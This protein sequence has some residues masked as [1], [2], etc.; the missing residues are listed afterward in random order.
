MKNYVFTVLLGR[1]GDDGY[2]AVC[3]AFPGCRARG[4][5]Q[6]ETIRKIQGLIDR[7][8]GTVI[9]S[10]KQVPKDGDAAFTS[11]GKTR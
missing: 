8:L 5:T 10:G 11:W 9:A 1:N 3:P 2:R 7:R 4:I 6:N